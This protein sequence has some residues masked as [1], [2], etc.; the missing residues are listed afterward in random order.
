MV[1][2]AISVSLGGNADM[3][4]QNI[5]EGVYTPQVTGEQLQDRAAEICSTSEY[6]FCQQENVA[7]F[8]YPFSFEAFY[9]SEKES[10]G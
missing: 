3:P 9:M 4:G 2:F 5:G 8:S 6:S 7:F 10:E 1:Q